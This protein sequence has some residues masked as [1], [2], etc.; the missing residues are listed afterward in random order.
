MQT[1]PIVIALG[2]NIGPRREALNRACR[3]LARHGILVVR[4]SRLYWTR[5]W[6]YVSQPDFV[7]G[8]ILVRTVLTPRALL[9]RCQAVEME[10]GRTRGGPGNGPRWGPRRIDLDLILYGAVRGNE[11]DLILPH[12]RLAER[13][14]VLAPLLDLGVFP[15]YHEHRAGWRALLEALPLQAR[16]IKHMERWISN[17]DFS[18]TG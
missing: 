16:T 1:E 10:L 13:D 14:F 6:G 2:C 5:P 11:S 17:H 18:R 9:A 8:A 12:P 7:N 15:R 4:R 3:L